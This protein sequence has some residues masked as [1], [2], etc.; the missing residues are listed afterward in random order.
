ME[1]DI[2]CG[3]TI[4]APGAASVNSCAARI[5]LRIVG[6]CLLLVFPYTTELRAENKRSNGDPL[7]G[8]ELQF[9]RS[10]SPV[11]PVEIGGTTYLFLLDTGCTRTVVDASLRA[12]LGTPVGFSRAR[13]AN[14]VVLA[15]RFEAP[16][17][18]VAGRPLRELMQVACVDLS[19]LRS[20]TELDAYGLLGM[21]VLG[22]HRIQI[23]FDQGTITFLENIA[24]VPGTSVPITFSPTGA[25]MVTV[26]V[27]GAGKREFLV[28]TGFAGDGGLSSAVFASLLEGG[29]AIPVRSSLS[30]SVDRQF[31]NRRSRIREISLYGFRHRGCIFEETKR[32]LL[33]AWYLSRYLV[34]FDFPG[35]TIYLA[36][37]SRFAQPS[38]RALSGARLSRENGV[39]RV[40]FIHPRTPAEKAGM[41][42]GDVIE[43]IDG[44]RADSLRLSGIATRFSIPGAYR[45]TIARGRQRLL[46]VLILEDPHDPWQDQP[47]AFA[48]ESRE[49]AN[50]RR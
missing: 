46:V 24:G 9:R 29:A 8:V 50:P 41:R 31:I 18:H 36:P 14:G 22:K 17:A 1:T 28:D 23:D 11:L 6:G 5:G 39:T 27:L 44:E 13:T 32:D 19:P 21:D 7:V 40:R 10:E 34:T 3:M 15:D 48:P 35:E 38:R 43:E 47:T 33:G 42:V 16:T 37:G 20:G 12:C 26:D 49:T 30:R 2:A 4:R 45:L 25:P